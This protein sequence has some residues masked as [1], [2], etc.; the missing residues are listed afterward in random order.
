MIMYENLNMI[1]CGGGNCYVIRGDKGDIL[2]DTGGTEWRGT[3]EEWL[4][5]YNVTLII[6]THGH[7]DHT[8]NA[9]YFS[10]LFNAPVMISP[11]DLPLVKDMDC[12]PYYVTTPVGSFI[13]M[14]QERSE[15]K[16]AE[17]FD[18]IIPAGDGVSL[19]KYGIDGSIISLEGHTKGS[20]GVL[21]NSEAGTDIY[22]GDA[23]MNTPISLF[24]AICESPRRARE[25]IKRL[26]RLI[27]L[28]IMPGHGDPLCCHERRYKLLVNGHR[29]IFG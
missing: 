25:S 16:A 11:Y 1:S 21:H 22:V 15:E 29:G 2:I 26:S 23:V 24:P 6:L 17:P 4:K 10:R 27:P 14:E 13:K 3:I 20:V 12:R 9:G 28:R 19:A 7:I 18:N 8:G 5:N